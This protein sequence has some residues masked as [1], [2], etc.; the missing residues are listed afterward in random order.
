[1]SLSHVQ[2]SQARWL[3]AMENRYS[4]IPVAPNEIIGN[5]LSAVI[6]KSTRANHRG[7]VVHPP[8]CAPRAKP[9]QKA[10]LTKYVILILL[11]EI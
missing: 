2:L 11:H 1:M 10:D 3:N 6:Y 4:I 8:L 9:H 7:S 5:D